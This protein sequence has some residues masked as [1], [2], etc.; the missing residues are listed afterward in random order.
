MVRTAVLAGLVGAAMLGGEA[1]AQYR[2]EPFT[3]TYD[4][5][6]YA[7]YIDQPEDGEAKGLVLLIPGHGRTEVT[8]GHTMRY[9]RE[10]FIEWGYATAIWDRAGNGLSEGEYDHNQPVQDSARE[11]AAALDALREMGAPGVDTVGFWGVSRG[12]WIAPLAIVED[13]DVD[14]WISVSG[15][16]GLETFGYMLRRN[17]ELDGRTPEQARRVS[18]AWA[19]AQRLLN[20][21]GATY[22]TYLETVEPLH[23]DPWFSELDGSGPPTREEFE[24]THRERLADP[25][26]IDPETGMPVMVRNFDRVLNALDMPV[27]AIW[28]DKD[29]QLDWRAARALYEA[30]LG[31]DPQSDLTVRV[32]ENCNHSMRVVETGAYREDLSADG[33]GQR[34]AGYTDA[35]RVFMEELAATPD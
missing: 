20:D 11:A 7:G 34:C 23:D 18:D 31:T 22:E 21:P 13:G 19:E 28:G 26:E 30:T 15:P 29:S 1:Q 27:L 5:L 6:T 24:A 9:E 10:R 14:F 3:F 8:E 32:L 25:M 4:G 2:A 35:M 16:D 12:G 33:L 17:V